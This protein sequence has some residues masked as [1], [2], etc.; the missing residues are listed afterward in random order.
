MVFNRKDRLHVQGPCMGQ[1]SSD[2]LSKAP[3]VSICVEC[4]GSQVSD[5]SGNK[6]K[7]PLDILLCLR[8]GIGGSALTLV[9]ELYC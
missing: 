6:V 4:V 8:K 5:S 3:V 7:C 2:R 1:Q 9:C